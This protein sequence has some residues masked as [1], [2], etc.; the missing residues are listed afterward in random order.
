MLST[1]V[2]HSTLKLSRFPLKQRD[3]NSESAPA[4]CLFLCSV[5]DLA[6]ALSADAQ[7]NLTVMDAQVPPPHPRTNLGSAGLSVVPISLPIQSN[8]A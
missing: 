3:W 6:D 2:F 4:L 7:G 5:P 8:A 1:A